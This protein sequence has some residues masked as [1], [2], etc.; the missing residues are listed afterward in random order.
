MDTKHIKE[1]DY[2]NEMQEIVDRSKNI[3]KITT[4]ENK[5]Q[6]KDS[7]WAEVFAKQ[8][9]SASSVVPAPEEKTQAANARDELNR[10]TLED[11]SEENH[12]FEETMVWYGESARKEAEL[13]EMQERERY[14][15]EER[16][17]WIREQREQNRKREEM[18]RHLRRQESCDSRRGD[19]RRRSRSRSRSS[20]Y[21]V[22]ER[23][24]RMRGRGRGRGNVRGRGHTGIEVA[25]KWRQAPGNN[26]LEQQ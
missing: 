14:E 3:L 4:N 7:Y 25:G 15:E 9:S 11:N 24:G 16:L 10:E 5:E 20:S 17:K 21:R 12:S 2:M 18:R 22:D 13:L 8:C 6:S 19:E 1:I 23:R 26:R